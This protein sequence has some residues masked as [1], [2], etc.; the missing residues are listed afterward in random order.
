MQPMYIADF[1]NPQP[2][3]NQSCKT[4]DKHRHASGIFNF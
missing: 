2:D 1:C 4:T 3:T